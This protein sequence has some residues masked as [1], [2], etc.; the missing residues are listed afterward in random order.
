M[1]VLEVTEDRY[2]QVMECI[3]CMEEKLSKIKSVFTEEALGERRYS[4]Y[5]Q[6]PYRD[7]NYRE[8]E[9]NRYM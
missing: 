7:Y 6:S 8:R 4:P 2:G 3:T 9:H 1:I 5:K